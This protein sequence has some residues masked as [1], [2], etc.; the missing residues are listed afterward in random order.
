[1]NDILAAFIIF[2]NE[3]GHDEAQNFISDRVREISYCLDCEENQCSQEAEIMHRYGLAEKIVGNDKLLDEDMILKQSGAPSNIIWENKNITG[4]RYWMRYLFS[5]ILVITMTT[6]AF[7]C[8]I[9]LQTASNAL[10]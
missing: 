9:K 6:I 5:A 1:M 2:K 3:E 4:V 7:Y 10:N 8:I